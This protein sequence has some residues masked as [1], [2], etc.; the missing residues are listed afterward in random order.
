MAM[1]R[2]LPALLPLVG[3]NRGVSWTFNNRHINVASSSVL[4]QT[5][6][7]FL[8]TYLSYDRQ[9]TLCAITIL[10]IYSANLAVKQNFS[11]EKRSRGFSFFGA[12]FV[13]NLRSP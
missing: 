13:D 5:I 12:I 2:S 3:L 10:S 4:C 8:C 1:S 11:L 7:P 9:I 6:V